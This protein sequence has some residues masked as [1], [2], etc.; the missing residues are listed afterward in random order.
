MD[1]LLPLKRSQVK[2]AAK[3]LSRAF[4]RDPLHM[5]YFPDASKRVQQIYHLMKY[6]IR[7]CMRFG[8]IFTTSSK[9]EGI[10]LWQ[11]EDSLVEQ[12]QEDKP[13]SLFVNWLLFRLRV[14][15]GESLEKVFSLYDYTV[16]VRHELVPSRHWYFFILGVDPKFQG[17]GFGS[18]LIS[19]IL[20]RIDK[21]QLPCYLDTNNEKNVGLAQHYGFKVVKRYQIPGSEVINWSMVR[22]N[23]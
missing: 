19:P 5:V 9:L 14:A 3:M 12:S 10:A 1:T 18:R 4:E 7:Y 16:S 22:E 6:S 13:R 8:E 23:P 17:Q 11:L 15:L 2:A 20:T 21:E